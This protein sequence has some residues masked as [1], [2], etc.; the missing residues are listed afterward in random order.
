MFENL[1]IAMNAAETVWNALSYPY[2]NC[3]S[4]IE[5]YKQR[6]EEN[7]GYWKNELEQAKLEK[8]AFEAVKKT[9]EKFVKDR[10]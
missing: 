8:E 5:L 4:N 6:E 9:L 3:E 1:R 10:M 2:D 7:P